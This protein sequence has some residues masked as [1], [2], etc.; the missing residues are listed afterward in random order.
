ML[1]DE[2]K[3][4]VC[5]RTTGGSKAGDRFV[6]LDQVGVEEWPPPELLKIGD[7]ITGVYK[8]IRMSEFPEEAGRHPNIIRGAEYIWESLEHL[9]N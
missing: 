2:G 7:E 6:T 8:R 1:N 5:I 9:Y 3:E 4:L